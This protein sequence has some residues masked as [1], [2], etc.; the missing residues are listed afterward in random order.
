[1][2]GDNYVTDIEGAMDSELDTILF[3]RWDKDFVPPR[4]VTHVVSTLTEIMEIL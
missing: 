1:M 2:I 4:P 3:N